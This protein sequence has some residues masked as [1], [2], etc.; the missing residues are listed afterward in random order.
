ML[1]VKPSEVD[2]KGGRLKV[3]HCKACLFFSLVDGGCDL[4]D[5]RSVFRDKK[6]GVPIG[7]RSGEPVSW[8][9]DW[10]PLPITLTIEG[11]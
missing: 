1:R 8:R 2:R 4:A 5:G 3:Y 7:T 6:A 11:D 10:C 9:P